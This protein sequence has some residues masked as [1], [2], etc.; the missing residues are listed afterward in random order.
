MGSIKKLL[1]F[2]LGVIISFA[3]AM[4]MDSTFVLQNGLNGYDGCKDT[5]IQL[6]GYQVPHNYADSIVVGDY[7]C[8]T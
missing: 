3:N 5:Y 7:Y 8:T 2:S 6:G 1:F 4:A